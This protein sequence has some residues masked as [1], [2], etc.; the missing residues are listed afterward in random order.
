M[1]Y[2]E[3]A[4]AVHRRLFLVHL[5]ADLFLVILH[6]PVH[7]HYAIGLLEDASHLSGDPHLPVCV[8]A[9]DLSH[10]GAQDRRTGRDLGNFDAC[11]VL[12][13]NLLE[14]GRSRL[15]I[16][17]LWALRFPFVT[18]FTWISATLLPLLR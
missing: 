3:R 11:G 16:S 18:K 10:Q 1:G 14:P 13:A 9:V 15:A 8:G 12:I 5:E 2:S 4:Y 17:W 6:K 7:I